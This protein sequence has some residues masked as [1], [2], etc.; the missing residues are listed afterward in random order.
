MYSIRTQLPDR[1]EAKLR[2][3]GKLTE[4]LV[5]RSIRGLSTL[6]REMRRGLRSAKRSDIDQRLMDRLQNPESQARYAGYM[7]KFVCYALHF[8]ANAEARMA[9]QEGGNE[10][11]DEDNEGNEDSLEEEGN[12]QL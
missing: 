8:L 10:G 11:S 4:L 7:V 6:A 12:K 1:G 5:K 9:G 2:Q 3:A